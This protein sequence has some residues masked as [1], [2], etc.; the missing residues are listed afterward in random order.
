[1]KTAGLACAM[2]MLMASS[3]AQPPETEAALG[4]MR[5]TEK[6]SPI[7]GD[8][9]GRAMV[10]QDVLEIR[11]MESK[12]LSPD[13][14]MVAVVIHRWASGAQGESGDLGIN[15][16]KELSIL[17]MSS[18]KLTRI[19]PTGPVKLSQSH[20]LWSPDSR[21]LAFLSSE[22]KDNAFLEVWDRATGHIRRLSKNGVDINAYVNRT[23]IEIGDIGDQM[24][25]I[26]ANHLLVVLLPEGIHA[27]SFDE[28]SKSD[29]MAEAGARAAEKGTKPSVVVASSP[30]D[31]ARIAALPSASLVM[32]D[33]LTG[34][35]R[36]LGRLPAWEVRPA[37]RS[38]VIS[39]DGAS[40]A[41]ISTV[42]PT[43]AISAKG[44]LRMID[45]A[46]N[47]LGVV[48]LRVRNDGIHW[49]EGIQPIARNI[50]GMETLNW[51]PDSSEFAL[52]GQSR[53]N[54]SAFCIAG[55]TL[56]TME[57]RPI[58]MFNSYLSA[59]GTLNIVKKIAWL[60]DGQLAIRSR[61]P[62][63]TDQE[64]QTSWWI[65]SGASVS[66][67][68]SDDP[69]LKDWKRATT[70]NGIVLETGELGRLIARD[71][72]GREQTLLPDLNPQLAQIEE[73]RWM[74][75]EY[76]S[77]DQSRQY[78]K[79]LLPHGYV[80]GTRY[81]TVVWVYGG[82]T[83]SEDGSPESRNN[84]DFS[85]LLLLAGHGYAVLFPSMPLAEAG[86]GI[87]PILHLND[88]VDPAIEKAVALGI[89]DPNRLAVMGHSY[90]GYSVYGLLT[91]THRYCAG[92]AMMGI[93]DLVSGYAEFDP[94]FRYSDPNYAAVAGPEDEESTQMRMGVP[95]WADPEKY[96]R[97][98]PVFSANKIETPLLIVS[99]DQ[100]GIIGMQ[101]EQMF[102]VLNRRGRRVEFVRY[103]GEQHGLESPPNIIDM[104]KR[105]FAWLDTYVKNPT[106]GA[107]DGRCNSNR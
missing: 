11:D 78:A 33:T 90:G 29:V 13:G 43:E 93:S 68:A 27:H 26:D 2:T 48:S 46:W 52:W 69:R 42:P 32:L 25:W 73:P 76:L 89:V 57:W 24:A 37:A 12:S 103:L 17:S 10:P 85:N 87:D 36:V 41:V 101:D 23:R 72:S 21:Q 56:A 54:R 98:S 104:W 55:V 31:P 105:V 81:P 5:N 95:L 39:P 65:V 20:P 106:S 16:R 22:S 64:L 61:S 50:P 70:S 80:A 102:T 34:T 67:L 18:K 77:L 94:R 82:S 51:R 14:K 88:G 53:E 15:H 63:N 62:N 66:A 86:S 28:Y 59:D 79:L 4:S 96:V 74:S 91:Q 49:I 40:A 30:P 99:G 60:P 44:S 58:A 9:G 1:M 38:V 3:S 83:Q 19:T 97:N 47:Q 71:E 6:V 35:S 84:G 92:I 100:D 45:V 107:N 75:F 7:H 8:P